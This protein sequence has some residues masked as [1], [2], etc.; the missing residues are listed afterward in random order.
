MRDVTD[1]IR[2]TPEDVAL[3]GPRARLYCS[4]RAVNA[5][6]FAFA[7]AVVVSD[8]LVPSVEAGPAFGHWRSGQRSP[9][10]VDLTGDPEWQQATRWAVERWNEAGAGF[11]IGWRAGEGRCEPDYG[12]IQVCEASSRRLGGLGKLHFH[13]I[14]DQHR[15][16]EHVRGARVRV[17]S[18]CRLD[19]GRR[20]QVVTHEL[21]HA[22]G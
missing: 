14:T 21:G 8:L 16:G 19:P 4:C 11:R 17:C 10:V 7:L 2:P 1:L 6:I 15:Q 12:R 13:G 20:R 22:L 18:D 9:V 5:L 3:F